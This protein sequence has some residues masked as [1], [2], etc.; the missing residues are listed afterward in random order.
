[1]PKRGR[2]TLCLRLALKGTLQLTHQQ[3]RRFNGLIVMARTVIIMLITV[4]ADVMIV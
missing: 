1:M 3:A 2:Q 4:T